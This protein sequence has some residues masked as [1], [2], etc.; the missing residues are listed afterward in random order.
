M[1]NRNINT[2]VYAQKVELLLRLMPIIMDEGV[3]AVHGGTA[4]NLFLKDLPRYS[5]DIDLTYIP[6]SDRLSK[7]MKLQHIGY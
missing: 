3:F 5:V 1:N 2:Q 4:I 6:L 7:V